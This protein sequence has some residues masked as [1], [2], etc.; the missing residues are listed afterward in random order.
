VEGGQAS[1]QAAKDVIA[2]RNGP[3]TGTADV[4]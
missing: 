3:L 1:G 2:D 4:R